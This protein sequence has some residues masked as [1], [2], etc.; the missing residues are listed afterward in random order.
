M[1]EEEILDEIGSNADEL[2][3]KASALLELLRTGFNRY[4]SKSHLD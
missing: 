2:H 1:S 3:E 4:K